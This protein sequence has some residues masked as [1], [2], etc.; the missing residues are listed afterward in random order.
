MGKKTINSHVKQLI[1]GRSCNPKNSFKKYNEIGA[2]EYGKVYKACINDKCLDKIA[3][4]NS[5]S[6]MSAEYLIT[7]KLEKLGVPTMYGYDKC[8][9]RD[10]LFSEFINGVTLKSFLQKRKNKMDPDEM[11]SI[12]IQVLYILYTIHKK[13]PSFRH[14]DLHLDNVMIL[15]KRNST[16]KKLEIGGTSVEFDDAKL[17][18][19]LMDFGLATM[20]GVINP[21]VRKSETFKKD[22]G[23]YPGSNEMYDV[24][25]FLSSLYSSSAYLPKMKKFIEDIFTNAYLVEKSGVVNEF[26]LRS[27]VIHKLPTYEEIFKNTYFSKPRNTVK[28]YINTIP[29]PVK[30]VILQK[31]IKTPVNQEKAKQKAMNVL[32]K[33]ANTKKPP[34]KAP[35]KRPTLMKPRAKPLTVRGSP[36]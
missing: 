12:I 11:K 13:Y 24:H 22:Y 21:I 9:N 16:T 4:K 32:K 29:A 7:K 6:N 23:I 33:M 18:V 5:N 26:R 34:S 8:G 30:K 14:H 28:M 35:P 15:R 17:E 1:T 2:G 25:L 20:N 3:V 10:F 19:K 27:D 31:K 36:K